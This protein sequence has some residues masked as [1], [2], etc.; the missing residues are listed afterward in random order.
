MRCF[1]AGAAFFSLE[2]QENLTTVKIHRVKMAEA[3]MAL[4]VKQPR[5]QLYGRIIDQYR[6]NHNGRGSVVAGSYAKETIM[7]YAGLGACLLG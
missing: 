2:C 6:Y 3:Q 5:G 1:L 7:N 4:K